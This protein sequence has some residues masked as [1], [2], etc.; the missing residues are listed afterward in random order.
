MKKKYFSIILYSVVVLSSCQK[1][2]NNADRVINPDTDTNVYIAGTEWDGINIIPKYWKNGTAVNLSTASKYVEPYSIY[3]S[4][5]DVY[6]AGKVYADNPAFPGDG[7]AIYWKNGNPVY[8]TDGISANSIIV[9]G[10]DVYVA[11][12][13]AIV[14]TCP[15]NAPC[16]L[17]VRF[18]AKYWKNGVPVILSDSTKINS[19]S[20]I[21]I[22]GSDV[23]VAGFESVWS[24]NTAKYWKNSQ[25]VVLSTRQSE[26][27]SIAVSGNDVYV[28]GWED[29]KPTYWK[30]GIPVKLSDET[31]NA[32]SIAVSGSGDVYVAGK[33]NTATGTVVKYWKNGNP[34]TLSSKIPSYATSIAVSGN[35]IYV[36]GQEVIGT[37]Y[38]AGY[39]KNG[40]WVTLS[41]KAD[42]NAIFTMKQ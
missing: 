19:A 29:F 38:C 6:V 13:G 34:V 7:I 11:G 17:P 35:D 12:D 24:L 27:N 9:S 36:A 10:N 18:V 1:E 25:P 41:D 4:G 42:A 2:I 26:T 30:N 32:N 14:Y 37:K 3:V 40:I 21:A 20:S 5:N 33:E 16:M 39:W 23:Y 28:A 22:S 8:L 15:R 31:G